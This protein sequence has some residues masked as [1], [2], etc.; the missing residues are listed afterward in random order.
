MMR[1][2]ARSVAGPSTRG[3]DCDDDPMGEFFTRRLIPGVPHGYACQPRKRP[4]GGVFHYQFHRVR[5]DVQGEEK[6]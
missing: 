5:M 1:R 6:L 2:T 4:A 3:G